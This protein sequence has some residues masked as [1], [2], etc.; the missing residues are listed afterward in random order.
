M[1][2]VTF[3]YI[4]SQLIFHK[5]TTITLWLVITQFRSIR[6]KCQEECWTDSIITCFCSLPEHM[7][8]WISLPKNYWQCR[9][10]LTV[11]L[12]CI[13]HILYLL[14][15]ECCD[16]GGWFEPLVFISKKP[17]TLLLTLFTNGLGS[18][19]IN[20][21]LFSCKKVG[22][23]SVDMLLMNKL[24]YSA[25]F[26][27]SSILQSTL[28]LILLQLLITYPSNICYCSLS[29]VTWL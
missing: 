9:Q 27:S 10:W 28:A 7:N 4:S 25:T 8:N 1:S 13:N 23:Y 17:P 24:W 5:T 6:L 3:T 18:T 20:K 21:V 26:L 2:V 12:H 11:F 16:S 14:S 19:S 29:A 22:V 15:L